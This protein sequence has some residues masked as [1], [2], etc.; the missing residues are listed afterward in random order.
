MLHPVISWPS[1]QR[2]RSEGSSKHAGTECLQR[3]WQSLTAGDLLTVSVVCMSCSAVCVNRK[4]IGPLANTNCNTNCDLNKQR[5]CSMMACLPLHHTAHLSLSLHFRVYLR[6]LSSFLTR[7]QSPPDRTSWM[8]TAGPSG[9]LEPPPMVMPKLP[10]R[11]IE[12]SW[13]T[14]SP[15]WLRTQRHG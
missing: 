11:A 5:L 4:V 13:I 14:P 2:S 7:W 15:G 12:I 3:W 9:L 6:L 8:K 10:D 1:T